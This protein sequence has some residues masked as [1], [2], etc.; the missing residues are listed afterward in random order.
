LTVSLPARN[1]RILI[2]GRTG[3]GK[4]VFALFVL[5]QADFDLKP[6]I[7]I[8]FKGDSN[9]NSIQGAEY[10]SLSN[11]LPKHPGIYILRP[12]IDQKGEVENLLWKIWETENIGVF[13]DEGYMLGQGASFSPA[14]RA[15]LTQGR[16]KNIG[17]ILNSQ[18][19]VWLDM[20]A[21]T[22]TNKIAMF[23]L[24]SANDRKTM[25]EMIGSKSAVDVHERLDKYHSIYYDIDTDTVIEL[26]PAPSPE[27]SISL[28]D[29]RLTRIKQARQNPVVNKA[30]PKRYERI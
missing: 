14:F 4:T 22:E 15:I 13:V 30:T 20:F 28:I 26:G 17:V 9:L 7:V 8:D 1:E 16:S 11:P 18:R 12:R 24:N 6:W 23:H 3:S 2:V 29:L 10:I 19:P 5:S 27:A 21:K 25:A